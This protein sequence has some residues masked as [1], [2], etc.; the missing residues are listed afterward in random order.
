MLKVTGARISTSDND[1]TEYL[2]HG[3]A[4]RSFDWCFQLADH[5]LVEGADLKNGLLIIS[6]KRELP[7]ALKPKIISFNES[8]LINS[9]PNGKAKAA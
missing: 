8:N 9:K 3:I 1:A 2:H 5:I 7:E 6:L 4:E